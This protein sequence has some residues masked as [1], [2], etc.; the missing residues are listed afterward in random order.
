[1]LQ[2]EANRQRKG[3]AAVL[4]RL[5]ARAGH[6]FHRLPLSQRRLMSAFCAPKYNV[7]VWT[8]ETGGVLVACRMSA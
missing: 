5:G 2:S 8:L 3:R 7:S 1:M 4:H 6:T